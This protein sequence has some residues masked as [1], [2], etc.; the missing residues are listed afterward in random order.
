MKT[1]KFPQIY[2]IEIHLKSS[3]TFCQRFGKRVRSTGGRYNDTRGSQNNRYVT[4]PCDFYQLDGEVYG[5]RL[6]LIDQI[7]TAYH[8]E[9]VIVKQHA[10]HSKEI[11]H[12]RPSRPAQP[13]EWKPHNASQYIEMAKARHLQDVEGR[14][15]EY[16]S[17]KP[18]ILGEAKTGHFGDRTLFNLYAR[19]WRTVW[20][21]TVEKLKVSDYSNWRIHYHDCQ[22]IDDVKMTD[23]PR[24]EMHDV[25]VRHVDRLR[26]D[27]MKGV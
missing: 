2:A 26:L 10:H 15:L 8:V 25:P 24:P 18:I 4:V 11:H 23:K 16:K 1:I 9:C 17:E 27:A 22:T 13:L 12:S 5:K 19:A 7:L 21:Q 6:N 14:S 20:R 3:D